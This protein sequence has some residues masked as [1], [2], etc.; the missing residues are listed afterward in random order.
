VA[1]TDL[2]FRLAASVGHFR[3]VGLRL[4]PEAA[5][6]RWG[7]GAAALV[8]TI[9]ALNW[10]GWATGIVVLTRLNPA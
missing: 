9:A 3:L 4:T 2:G 1:I 8:V 7:R 6:V 10:V 5:L